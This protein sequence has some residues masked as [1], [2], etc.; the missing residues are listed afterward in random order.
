MFFD[1]PLQVVLTAASKGTNQIALGSQL[2]S[3]AQKALRAPGQVGIKRMT[4]FASSPWLSGV[5]IKGGLS[6]GD[7]SLCLT[8][9]TAKVL[10][11]SAAAPSPW[12]DDS[13]LWPFVEKIAV[14]PRADLALDLARR[15]FERTGEASDEVVGVFS[16]VAEQAQDSSLREQARVWLRQYVLRQP[17]KVW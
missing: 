13:I 15:T 12:S 2:C 9:L 10:S 6:L 17:R 5:S 3:W 4:S 1:E 8:R 11:R 7:P 16:R 14:L